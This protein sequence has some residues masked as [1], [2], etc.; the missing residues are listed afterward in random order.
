MKKLK[1]F[2]VVTL[3]TVVSLLSA[4]HAN[5]IRHIYNNS[6]KPWLFYFQSEK[7]SVYFSNCDSGSRTNGPCVLQPH[8]ITTIEYSHTGGYVRGIVHVRLYRSAQYQ[9]DKGYEGDG[10]SGYCPHIHHRGRT[11]AVSLNEPAN[12]DFSIESDT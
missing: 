5:C 12:G 1:K 6:S 3:L 9:L 10:F 8:T 2:V 7:G 4:A 11:G